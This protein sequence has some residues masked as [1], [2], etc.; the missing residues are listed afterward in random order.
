MNA[1]AMALMEPNLPIVSEAPEPLM[2]APNITK[3]LQRTAAFLKVIIREPTAVPNTLAASLAPNDQP[4]NNP[5]DR[6]N[7]N[8]FNLYNDRF[9]T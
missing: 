1:P 3:M 6:K 4:R 8:I 2:I 7:A 9:M 5:L